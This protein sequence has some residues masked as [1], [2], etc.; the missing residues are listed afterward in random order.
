MAAATANNNN[1]NN[2]HLLQVANIDRAFIL[3]SAAHK[4]ETQTSRNSRRLRTSA[5]G[6]KRGDKRREKRRDTRPNGSARRRLVGDR[7]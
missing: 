6:A 1:K 4:L 3:V 5:N 7:L 2:H